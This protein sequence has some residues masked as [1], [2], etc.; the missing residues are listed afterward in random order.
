MAVRKRGNRFMA[1]FMVAGTRYREAFAT[2][3]DAERWETDMRIAL[4]RGTS[5][6]QAPAGSVGG[7]D[8]GTIKQVFR[9][10]SVLHWEKLNNS[11]P[12]I[13]CA[14][15]YL[16]WVGENLSPKEALSLSKIRE[17]VEYLITERRVK[18]STINYHLSMICVLLKYADMPR[19]DGL[20]WQKRQAGRVRY[21]TEEEVNL[22]IQTLTLWGEDRIR[23]LLI[24][25]VDTGAR[26]Q[27]EA[28]S[29]QWTDF[30]ERFVTFKYTKNG[31]TRTIPLTKRAQEAVERQR[32]R[33]PN[34]PWRGIG[35]TR[36][37]KVWDRV[38]SHIPELDD[39]VLYTA[40]HTCA[41]WQVIAG[42]D[43]RRVM[44]WMGH[45]DIKTTMNYAHLSPQHLLDNVAAL[46]S[47]RSPKLTV[48]SRNG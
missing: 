39:T 19:P 5:L 8:K 28:L 25:L 15:L 22:V 48:I 33:N 4:D 32:N 27:A 18:N 41:S 7:V 44:M 42:I 13:R 16:K 23:D 17:Y 47:V 6:P 11:K 3:Q 36:L 14:A 29:L 34:G 9:S 43:I 31:T 12:T 20:P 21:F 37:V 40:R 2:E 30:R 38:R 26:P 45:T 35:Y 1:D 10:A 46:E 24:F